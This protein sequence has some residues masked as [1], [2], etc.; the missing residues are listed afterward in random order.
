MLQSGPS[1][2]E[3]VEEMQ[4]VSESQHAPGIEGDD[5]RKVVH[6]RVGKGLPA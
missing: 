5:E 6:T 3:E 1:D 4:R 2:N